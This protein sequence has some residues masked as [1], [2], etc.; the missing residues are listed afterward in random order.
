MNNCKLSILL[1]VLIFCALDA[2]GQLYYMTNEGALLALNEQ[3][4]LRLSYGRGANQQSDKA[5]AFQLGYSPIKHI[6]IQYSAASIVSRNQSSRDSKG[7]LRGG[8]IGSYY[9]IDIYKSN[10]NSD[11]TKTK[12][13][14]KNGILFDFYLGYEKGE[15]KN[16]YRKSEEAFID[17]NKNFAQ[18]GVHFQ[19]PI[20]GIN[21]IV[22]K[23]VLDYKKFR[24]A[25]ADSFPL[26]VVEDINRFD[27][28]NFTESTIR[29]ILGLKTTKIYFS[30]TWINIPKKGQLNIFDNVYHFGVIV[31]LDEFFRRR[32][33]N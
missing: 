8:S 26:A 10:S 1:V 23:G 33:H 24:I 32:N 27:T 14:M 17:F 7:K 30:N 22:K 29:V 16:E 4:D 9:F 15:I 31:E 5:G 11:Q 12:N 13:L 6:G 21:F 18:L 2:F 28:F 19:G 25:T 20:F 3:H